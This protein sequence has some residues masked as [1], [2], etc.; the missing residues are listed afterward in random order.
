MFFFI[1]CF[2]NLFFQDWIFLFCFVFLM[3]LKVLSKWFRYYCFCLIFLKV[4]FNSLNVCFCG[5]NASSVFFF[6][7]FFFCLGA[8]CIFLFFL[9]FIALYVW[10]QCL[11]FSSSGN[12]DFV[13]QY[14][15]SCVIVFTYLSKVRWRCEGRGGV[16]TYLFIFYLLSNVF[17]PLFILF[18]FLF[19]HILY[20]TTNSNI[21]FDFFHSHF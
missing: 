2:V 1:Y 20:I 12:E 15:H 21:I 8:P 9:C 4:G 5:C 18:Y 6:F 13:L 11:F 3:E 10:F 7:F 16:N 19:L 14:C 17:T